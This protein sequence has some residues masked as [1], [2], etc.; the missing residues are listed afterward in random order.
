MLVG[1]AVALGFGKKLAKRLTARCVVGC[2]SPKADRHSATARWTSSL[3]SFSRTSPPLAFSTV[4]RAMLLK[5]MSFS[6][7]LVLLLARAA[8]RPASASTE[9][10]GFIKLADCVKHHSKIE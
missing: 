1:M 5:S 6:D 4:A 2:S 8:L 7:V 10:L 3:A 9:V